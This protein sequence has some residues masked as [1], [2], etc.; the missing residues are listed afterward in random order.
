MSEGPLLGTGEAAAQGEVMT[1]PTVS[2]VNVPPTVLRAMGA[3]ER[4]EDSMGFGAERKVLTAGPRGGQGPPG[5]G[6]PLEGP[7]DPPAGR[8]PCCREIWNSTA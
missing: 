3:G 7:R 1:P 6:T 2:G 5:A 4:W 8:A